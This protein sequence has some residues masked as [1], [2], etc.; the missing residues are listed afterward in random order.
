MRCDIILLVEDNPE[1]VTQTLRA[2]DRNQIANQVVVARDGVEALDYL[3][4]TGIHAGRDTSVQPGLVL[5]DLRLPRLT[6]LEVLERLRADA[7]TAHVPVVVLTS[8]WEERDM[9]ESYS[10]GAN[11]YVRKPVQMTDFLNA[12][13][14]LGLYWSLLESGLALLHRDTLFAAAAPTGPLPARS[15]LPPTTLMW[16][17]DVLVS[18]GEPLYQVVWDALAPLGHRVTHAKDAKSTFA[19]LHLELPDVL[20]VDDLLADIAGAE[21]IRALRRS[22]QRDRATAILLAQDV[23]GAEQDLDDDAVRVYAPPIDPAVLIALVAELCQERHRSIWLP[24]NEDRLPEPDEPT[25]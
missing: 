18:G 24:D 13:R 14:H 2:F 16:P 11:I 1:D 21:V 4:G 19:V 22:P 12:A 20:V 6:G 5:L 3:Y 10:L 9:V 7:R 15:N 23:A 25:G 8:S 17:M